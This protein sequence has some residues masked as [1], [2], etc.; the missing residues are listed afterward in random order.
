MNTSGQSYEAQAYHPDFGNEVTHGVIWFDAMSLHFDSAQT[1]VEIPIVRVRVQIGKGV[2][3]RIRFSDPALPGWEIFTTD[4]SIFDDRAMAGDSVIREQVVNILGGR[5]T[6]RR[7][8]ITMWFAGGCA[9]IVCLGWVGMGLMVHALVNRISPA[10]EKKMGDAYLAD[11]KAEFKFV[12]DTNKLDQLSALAKPLTDVAGGGQ[13]Q[14]TFHLV[15]DETPNAF[16]LPGGHV[17]VHTGLLAMADKPEELL[18]VLAHEIAHVR[19]KHMFRQQ[20]AS[21]GPMLLFGVLLSGGGRG[22]L[23][24]V[25][26]TSALLV[27]QNFSQDYETEADDV[28]W[29]YL[30]QANLNPHGMISMFQ[31]FEA[32]EEKE[33]ADSENSAALSSHPTTKKRLDRLEKK[34]KKLQPQAGFAELSATQFEALRHDYLESTTDAPVLIPAASGARK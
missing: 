10:Q 25:S 24:A 13:L 32:Y 2:D 15:D 26:G 7:L 28:G 23:G 5:E 18:G 21:A 33:E 9:A 27:E 22:V 19:E 4:Q 16:A 17:V 34:W 31:K 1:R 8:K 14:F 6:S 29:S 3:E 20:I 30:L 11:L 12:D